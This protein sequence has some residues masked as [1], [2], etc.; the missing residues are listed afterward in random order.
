MTQM[1]RSDAVKT[2]LDAV[3]DCSNV[4]SLE[5][6]KAPNKSSNMLKFLNLNISNHKSQDDFVNYINKDICK[7]R[8]T[9]LGLTWDD[10][11]EF[12]TVSQFA[13]KLCKW[14][15][16][17]PEFISEKVKKTLDYSVKDSIIYT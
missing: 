17:E 13:D 4:E 3:V 1:H 12:D 15:S 16:Y 5:K 2:I 8:N 6:I 7:S 10:L 14:V 9:D 11:H